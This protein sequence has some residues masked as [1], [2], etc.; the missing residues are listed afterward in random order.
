MLYQHMLGKRIRAARELANL[1]QAELA[2]ACGC[3]GLW[4]WKI[5]SS[6]AQ[7]SLALLTKIATQLGVT[8]DSLVSDPT[9][10][11]AEIEA[12]SPG[13]DVKLCSATE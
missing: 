2:K 9:E 12:P 7:P 11:E 13:D 8:L 10:P 3:S 5:E 4:L 1:G 6:A